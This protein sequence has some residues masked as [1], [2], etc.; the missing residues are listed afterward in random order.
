MFSISLFTIFHQFGV[1]MDAGSSHS[2]I[3]VFTWRGD[4]PLGTADIKLKHRCFVAGMLRG[5]KIKFTVLVII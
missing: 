3:F 4:K 2:E 5:Q 1:V